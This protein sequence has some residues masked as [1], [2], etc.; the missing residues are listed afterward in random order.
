LNHKKLG[1][2]LCIIHLALFEFFPNPVVV[3][4]PAQPAFWYINGQPSQS[5]PAGAWPDV[6]KIDSCEIQPG[7][8][9]FTDYPHGYSVCI[10]AG[11]RPDFSLSAVRSS[12]ENPDTHIEIYYDNFSSFNPNPWDYMTDANK[13]LL[14]SQRNHIATQETFEWSGLTVNRL[15]WSRAPLTAVKGDRNYYASLELKLF[16]DEY[17]TIFIKSSKPIDNDLEILHSF[18]WDAKRGTAGVFRNP[19][20]VAPMRNKETI[21]FLKK[22]FAKDSPLR[23]G[24]FDYNAPDNLQSVMDLESRLGYKFNFLLRYQSLEDFPP[25]AGLEKAYTDGRYTQL[26]METTHPEANNA[27]RFGESQINREV[28]YEILDGKYDDHFRKYAQTLKNFGHPVLFRFDNEMNGD[29]CWYSAT[30]SGKDTNIYKAAWRHVHRLFDEV[31]VDNVLWVWNPNDL[32]F[33]RFKWNEALMYYPGDDVV[34]IVGLTGYN[35]GTYFRD[36]PWREF[37]AIYQPLY[38]DYSAWFDKPFIIGEF[39][40]NS[41]GGDKVAWINKMFRE[42]PKFNRIKVAI[43]WSGIDWDEAG[44]PGRIY[45]LDETDATVDAFRRG[46]QEYNN[47]K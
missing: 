34:D 46:L 35:T 5:P 41:V 9:K 17:Y 16:A 38:A 8:Q 25:V 3:A 13:N 26:S 14:S 37:P 21:D 30:F 33:P 2:A 10:P 20:P 6:K 24:L 11:L 44:R 47:K 22:Y 19:V 7:Y 27:L 28:L 40:S 18:R 39:G 36:D 12:F 29:W 45:K 31:G 42:M 23:W 32:S 4:A 43:W 1:I 15:K